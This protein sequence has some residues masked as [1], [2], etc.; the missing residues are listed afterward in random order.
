MENET[1]MFVQGRMLEGA[2]AYLRSEKGEDGVQTLER[3]T[4]PLIFDAHRM[5]PLS[6]LS[7]LQ[8]LVLKSVYEKVEPAHYRDLAI[9][10]YRAFGNTIGGATLTNI[11]NTPQAMLEKIQELWSV[12]VSFGERKL[13]SINNIERV[14]RIEIKGDPRPIA[15]LEGA[16]IGCLANVGA[17]A[18]TKVLESTGGDEPSCLI[19]VRW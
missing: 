7:K 14:A 9:A 19:E 6:E 18:K 1:N 3:E 13:L 10:T 4:G 2:I 8:E 17:D 5:Y 15:Y 12:V 16:I 11:G